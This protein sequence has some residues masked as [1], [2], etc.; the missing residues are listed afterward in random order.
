MNGWIIRTTVGVFAANLYH[1]NKRGGGRGVR[2]G[3]GVRRIKLQD[4]HEYIPYHL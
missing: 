2:R 3:K 1:D 4:I